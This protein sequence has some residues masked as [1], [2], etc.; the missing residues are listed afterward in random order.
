[1]NQKRIFITFLW[2]NWLKKVH[3]L[4]CYECFADVGSSCDPTKTRDCSANEICLTMS[5]KESYEG[6]VLNSFVKGCASGWDSCES[7]CDDDSI[8]DCKESCC[9]GNLCNEES[10]ENALWYA[11]SSKKTYNSG[12]AVKSNKCLMAVLGVML[13]V[14]K[15]G[16]L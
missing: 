3:M 14:L 12:N 7:N 10:D 13:F 8:F 1:M 15:I 4:E 5:Y 11:L 9:R 2:L 6:K 16:F